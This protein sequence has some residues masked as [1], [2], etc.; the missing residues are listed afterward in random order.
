MKN[1]AQTSLEKGIRTNLWIGIVLLALLVFGLGGWVALTQLSAAAIASGKVVVESSRKAVQHVQGG[2]VKRLYVFEGAMVKAGDLLMSLDATALKA[3]LAVTERQAVELLAN[4]AR[5]VAERDGQAMPG[6]APIDPITGLQ[7]PQEI[8][9]AQRTLYEARKKSFAGQINQLRERVKQ[10]KQL[11][12]GLDIQKTAKQEEFSILEDRLSRLRKLIEKKLVAEDQLMTVRSELAGARG[13]VG[14]LTAEIARTKGMISELEYQIYQL[15]EQQLS[16]IIAELNDNK[17]KL[18]GHLES[19]MEALDELSKLEIR[20][21][22]SG[23]VHQ[24]AVH[25]EGGVLGGGDVA[26]SIVP[27]NDRLIVE[28]KLAP[29][30]INEVRTGQKARLRFAAFDQNEVPELIGTVQTIA[31]DVVED[32]QTGQNHYPLRILINPDEIAKLGGERLQ[33]GIPVEAFIEIRSRTVLAYL[34]EPL[35]DHLARAFRE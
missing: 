21:P 20:A 31:A 4:N 15:R 33:P 9:E 28:V 12:K 8:L 19:R 26:M 22:V 1:P 14:K 5:L 7:I 3:K 24:L 11:I 32:M 29:D 30:K 25:T 35:S 17:A 27:E 18:S 6:Q 10:N 34:L 13:E 23:I 16:K 2:L